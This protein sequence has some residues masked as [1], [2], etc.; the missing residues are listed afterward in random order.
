MTTIIREGSPAG[1]WKALHE[2]FSASNPPAVMDVH[3]EISTQQLREGENPFHIL[4]RREQLAARIVGIEFLQE[5]L[6]DLSIYVVLRFFHLIPSRN[7]ARSLDTPKTSADNGSRRWCTIDTILAETKRKVHLRIS[8]IVHRV[9]WCVEPW[10]RSWR[11]AYLQ[12][13]RHQS[14]EQQYCRR[15]NLNI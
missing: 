14:G 5:S 2:H 10:T 6:A 15:L 13:R 12:R 3:D 7:N 4:A 9:R 8:R 11:G 1:S